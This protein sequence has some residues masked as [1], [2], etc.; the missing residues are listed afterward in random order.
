M[1]KL[2][3]EHAH[4]E[5]CPKCNGKRVVMIVYGLPTDEAVEE[6]NS[7]KDRKELNFVLGGCVIRTEQFLCHDCNISW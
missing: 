3:D 7:I 5:I 4:D 6:L 2:N 1:G